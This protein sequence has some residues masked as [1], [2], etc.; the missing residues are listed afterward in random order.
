MIDWW[1]VFV[2]ALWI[3]GLSIVLAAFSYHDWLRRETGR[4]WKEVRAQPSWQFPFSGGMLL[5]CLGMGLGREVAWWERTLWG[6]LAAS[7]VWQTVAGALA[8]R[9]PNRDRAPV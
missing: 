7:F 2:S 5:F 4:R 8:M 6:L 3:L 9:R 1:F